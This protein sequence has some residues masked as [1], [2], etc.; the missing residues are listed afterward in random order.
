[1]TPIKTE[2]SEAVFSKRT[3]LTLIAAAIVL[4]PAGFLWRQQTRHTAFEKA[5]PVAAPIRIVR[6]IHKHKAARVENSEAVSLKPALSQQTP[7]D[8]LAMRLNKSD[9]R[10]FNYIFEGKATYRNTPCANASVLVRVT[11]SYGTQVKGTTTDAD[12]SYRLEVAARALPNEDFA[13][14][15]EAYAPDSHKVELVGRKIITED[16]TVSIRNTF[17][18]LS[19]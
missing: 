8:F 6:R 10:F 14:S 17:A 9:P 4:I 13:W 2:I 7:Q 1:M 3:A 15:M 19:K 11:T 18:F 12:G 16:T 5:V